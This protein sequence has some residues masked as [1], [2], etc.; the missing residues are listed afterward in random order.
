MCN[1]MNSESR[2]KA[3]IRTTLAV[4][5][6]VALL[7]DPKAVHADGLSEDPLNPAAWTGSL[8]AR[9]V[10]ARAHTYYFKL[11]TRLPRSLTRERV[12]DLRLLVR[13]TGEARAVVARSAVGV[14]RYLMVVVEGTSA[15]SWTEARA[16]A[17]TPSVSPVL[18][19]QITPGIAEWSVMVDDQMQARSPVVRHPDSRRSAGDTTPPVP[20]S[21]G[22]PPVPGGGSASPWPSTGLREGIPPGYAP[23]YYQL[24][25]RGGVMTVEST[26]TTAFNGTVSFEVMSPTAP[27]EAAYAIWAP[28]HTYVSPDGQPHTSGLYS[29][30]RDI[31]AGR[32]LV[33]VTRE[34]ASS[35]GASYTLRVR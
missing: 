27:L 8:Q 30:M 2:L 5:S 11:P 4:G 14:P 17:P 15:S 13:G 34:T 28:S 35:S 24:D 10:D 20:A 26:I 3:A 19:V 29:D 22:F 31:P 23:I 33:R 25:W 12:V 7:A 6:L 32:Y 9:N 1:K 16:T 18:A 21:G